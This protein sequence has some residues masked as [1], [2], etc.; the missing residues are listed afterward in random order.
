[1]AYYKKQHLIE[2]LQPDVVILQEV[3]KKDIVAA[4][5]PFAAWTGTNPNK[6]L[7]LI[8]FADARY[9][10]TESADPLCRGTFPFRWTDSTSS[11]FG[12]IS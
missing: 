1:M 11:P 6:G 8:G 12:H 3:A 10:M 9:K 7:G 4:Q 5:R 2:A